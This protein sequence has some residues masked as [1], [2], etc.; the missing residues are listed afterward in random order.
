MP[1]LI[2]ACVGSKESLS[3]KSIKKNSWLEFQA[4]LIDLDLSTVNFRKIT[5]KED[6]ITSGI[7]Y[8]DN[9]YLLCC[10][11]SNNIPNDASQVIATL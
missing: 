9:K 4:A 7:F 3:I 5:Q 2:V 6:K 10:M 8:R 11:G 1:V